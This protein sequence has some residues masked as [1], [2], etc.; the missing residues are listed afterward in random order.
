MHVANAWTCMLNLHRYNHPNQG[1]RKQWGEV[2]TRWKPRIWASFIFC[3]NVW[4]TIKIRFQATDMV[5]PPGPQRCRSFDTTSWS[6]NFH[7][8][9]G[10]EWKSL[11]KWM[12]WGYPHFRKPPYDFVSKPSSELGCCRVTHSRNGLPLHS[13]VRS[14]IAHG[15]LWLWFASTETRYI[16]QSSL[17][18]L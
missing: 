5:A 8:I 3:V 18:L 2:E 11:F 10:L 16:S 6:R 12:I 17:T 4:K 1:A 7:K 9:D 14:Q 13:K 15:Q